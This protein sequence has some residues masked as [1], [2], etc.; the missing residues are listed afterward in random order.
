MSAHSETAEPL[1]IPQTAPALFALLRSQGRGLAL[2][3]RV[4]AAHQFAM[5]LHSGQ[6]RASAKPFV[7]HLVGTAATLALVPVASE[8]TIVAGLLHAAY[9]NGEWGDGLRFSSARKRRRL[10]AR[11]GPEVEERVHRYTTFEWRLESVGSIA[12]SR[13]NAV[14]RD[15][16]TIRLANEVDDYLD[17]GVLYK[18]NGVG[19]RTRALEA[20]PHWLRLADELGLAPLGDLLGRAIEPELPLEVP[21]PLVSRHDTSFLVAPPSHRER[22]GALVRRV[23]FE[24]SRDVFRRMVWLAR[25][26]TGTSRR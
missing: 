15:V 14:D 22:V 18:A 2:L 17:L 13:L 3:E 9:A 8:T 16:V 11:V 19:R 1:A 21:E 5:K 7:C 23:A 25:R 12:P 10:R 20:L 24:R 4:H 26:M 6:Y